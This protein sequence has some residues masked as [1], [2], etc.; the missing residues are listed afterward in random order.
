MRPAAPRLR[1]ESGHEAELARRARE[2][3]RTERGAGEASRALALVT[4]TLA[5]TACALPAS[6]VV[7][8][9]ARLGRLTP[10]PLAGGGRRAVAFVDEQPVAVVDL[11]Q[12]AGL[13]PRPTR[14]MAE[15]P[16]VV[17]EAPGG[18]VA[19]AVEGPLSLEEDALAQSAAAG[20]TPG[21]LPVVGRLAGGALLLAADRVASAAMGPGA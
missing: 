8:A 21:R 7:R 12:L 1:V 4:F 15:A 9:V 6:G 10:V 11:C 20:A 5:G 18:R 19:L 2:L 17:V 14:A 16:A 3:G 13:P